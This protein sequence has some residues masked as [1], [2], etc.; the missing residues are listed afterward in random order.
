MTDMSPSHH[1]DAYEKPPVEI[2]EL[3][4]KY[5][6]PSR[7][8]DSDLEIVDF[9]RGLTVSQQKDVKVIGR[10]G[11]E[12]LAFTFHAFAQSIPPPDSSSLDTSRIISDSLIYEH[13]RLPGWRSETASSSSWLMECRVADSAIPTPC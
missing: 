9:K 4:K 6:K 8:L 2:R 13:R 1:F 5:Q 11:K 7:A 12:C 10:I 3:Y